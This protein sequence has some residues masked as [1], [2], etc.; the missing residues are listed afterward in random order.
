M[1]KP[2]ETLAHPGPAIE[3]KKFGIPNNFITHRSAWRSALELARDNC[4]PKTEDTDDRSY[5]EHEL[6]AYDRSFDRLERLMR[7]AEPVA[8]GETLAEWAV[9]ATPADIERANWR[10][11]AH[12]VR[13]MRDELQKD[14]CRRSWIDPYLAIAES[15]GKETVPVQAIPGCQWMTHPSRNNG[16]PLP[17]QMFEVD[18]NQRYRPFD[19][20]AT[21][22]AWDEK[23][24]EWA[25]LSAAPSPPAETISNDTIREVFT[26]NGFTVKEGQTDLRPY[27]YSAARELLALVDGNPVS[28][29]QESA[30]V[31]PVR[32]DIEVQ[33]SDIAGVLR[34]TEE[35]VQW[36]QDN[37]RGTTFSTFV[38][39]FPY[40]HMNASV[41]YKSVIAAIAAGG[42]K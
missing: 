9:R 40:D 10:A 11:V 2:G 39:E 34:L 12:C 13:K 14:G 36:L 38:N 24:D 37:G 27:V 8:P 1:E 15:C 25:V 35:Y 30:P 22:I 19:E 17:V 32:E 18:G 16:N 42:A 31:L 23:G 6:A 28:K 26:R 4:A 41:V 3:P 20:S 33:P 29:Q 7:D 5:W 21:E